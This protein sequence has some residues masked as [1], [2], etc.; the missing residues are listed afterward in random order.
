MVQLD[1][2]P[3]SSINIS[4]LFFDFSLDKNNY[5][6]TPVTDTDF[7]NEVHLYI[8]YN[9]T[10]HIYWAV[11]GGLAWPGTA[12]KEA[13]NNSSTYELIESQIVVTY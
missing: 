13:S 10:D 7:T 6:G 1:A 4:L 2:N 12:A 3:T 9:I 5:L 8:N 11:V